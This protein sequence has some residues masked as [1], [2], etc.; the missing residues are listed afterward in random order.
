MNFDFTEEQALLRA[1][2]ERWCASRHGGD[3]AG[4]LRRLRAEPSGFARADWASLAGLGLFALPFA[5]DDGGLGGGPVD[6]IA[7]AEPLGR[8]LAPEPVTECLV[9]AGAL[10]ARTTPSHAR[11]AALAQVMAGEMMAAAAI[12][13]PRGRTNIAHVE[14]RARETGAG[15]ILSGAKSAV[16]QGG[17]ADVF[18][19]SARTAGE[20]RAR[21]G[22]AL[23]RVP[24]DA[25]GLEVRPW[26]AIDGSLAA[27]LTLH[28]V[29]LGPEARLSGAPD[30]AGAIEAALAGA[31]LA[32]A[33]EM[34]GVAGLLLETTIAHV[35]TRAQFGRPIGSFQVV[36]H[37][38]TDCHVA[39]EQ[40]RSMVYRAALAP[41]E[42]FRRAATGAHAYVAEAARLVAHEAVQFHGAMGVTEELLVGHGLKRIQ[43][44]ARLWTSPDEAMLAWARAA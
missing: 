7:V 10:L 9:M 26:R 11:P 4:T 20:V 5:A 41:P 40:A 19:V 2:V 31:W 36:Q 18:L 33:A 39:Q 17:A 8:S 29:A 44:L 1:S 34:L 35:K 6:L 15:W 21:E 23:F 12:T 43:M 42:G 14:C 25:P 13:E 28:D 30:V 3:I 38:L 32:A 37:R 27:E 22:I 24:R 16:W